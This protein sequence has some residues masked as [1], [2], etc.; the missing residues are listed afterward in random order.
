MKTREELSVID[1]ADVG[2]DHIDMETTTKTYFVEIIVK[3]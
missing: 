3:L 2:L 1:Q